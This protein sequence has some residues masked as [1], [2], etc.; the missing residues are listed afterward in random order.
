MSGTNSGVLQNKRLLGCVLLLI[1]K[2]L[3]D[4]LSAKLLPGSSKFG[5]F[6][7]QGYQQLQLLVSLKMHFILYIVHGHSK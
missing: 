2:E 6:P 7:Y 1:P 3:L 4:A 5:A